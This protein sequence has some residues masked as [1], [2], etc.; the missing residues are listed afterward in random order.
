MEFVYNRSIIFDQI[1]FNRDQCYINLIRSDHSRGM[2][3]IMNIE[4]QRVIDSNKKAFPRCRKQALDRHASVLCSFTIVPLSALGSVS[5]SK[6]RLFIPS[7]Q[8]AALNSYCIIRSTPFSFFNIDRTDSSPNVVPCIR[9]KIQYTTMLI[10]FSID[11]L[12][13]NY[14]VLVRNNTM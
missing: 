2:G 4:Y 6:E 5:P 13:A 1:F 3:R 8:F 11:D 12:L 14:Y 10:V 9:N 7:I